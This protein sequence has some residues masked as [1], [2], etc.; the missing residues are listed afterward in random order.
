MGRSRALGDGE[1]PGDCANRRRSVRDRDG[2][3]RIGCQAASTIIGLSEGL[4]PAHGDL[5]DAGEDSVGVG[6]GDGCAWIVADDIS[7]VEVERRRREC[8]PA[9]CL[10]FAGSVQ[11]DRNDGPSRERVGQRP[12]PRAPRRRREVDLEGAALVRLK[13][14]A[15]AGF[16]EVSSDC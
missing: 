9:R 14:S 1:R 15:G 4:R 12:G 13:D 3:S 10:G 8:K 5:G 11:R 2:T 6:H 16:R 7:V